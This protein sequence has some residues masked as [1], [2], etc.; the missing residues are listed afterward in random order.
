MSDPG[1]FTYL[2]TV[3]QVTALVASRIYP[4]RAPQEAQRP[5]VV[6][7]R[8][9]VDRQQLYCGQSALI[10]GAYQFDCY[11]VSATQADQVHRALKNAMQDYAGLMGAVEVRHCHLTTD[12]VSAD[13]DPLIHRVTQLWDIWHV[14][15]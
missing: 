9:G 12:F 4:N 13:E 2:Q 10:K 14:E 15:T 7:T 8:V 3:M 11:G 5:F 1:F 6:W